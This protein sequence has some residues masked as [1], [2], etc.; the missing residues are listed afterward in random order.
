MIVKSA[1]R[2]EIARW[3]QAIKLNIEFFE[4][5]GGMSPIKPRRS[6][7]RQ[8]TK[9][10]SGSSG[11]DLSP[12]KSK[13]LAAV[14]GLPP[15]D[16]FL[17][18]ELNRTAT[19]LSGL[20]APSA[21]NESGSSRA[22]SAAHM[23]INI[24]PM[25]DDEA[26]ESLSVLEAAEQDS[27]VDIGGEHSVSPNH[28]IPHEGVFDLGVL[29]LK[30]QIESL[31]QLLDAIDVNPA[32]RRSHSPE[33]DPVPMH[34]ADS[35]QQAVKDALKSSLMT[36]STL[37]SS[38]TVMSQDRERYL[39][40]RI[41]REI[42]AR[43]VW[44][45]NMMTVAEQQ[46]ETDRQL[47]EAAKDNEK[48][49]KALRKARGVLAGLSQD[50]QIPGSPSFE[51][52]L[53]SPPPPENFT[54]PGG[55]SMVAPIPTTLGSTSSQPLHPQDRASISN[56]SEVQE[57]VMAAGAESDEEDEDDE[58]F[59]AIETNQIPNLQLHD[60]IAFPDKDRVTT[61]QV[62]GKSISL[63]K[64]ETAKKGSIKELL[65][66]QSLDPYVH[67]RAKLPID[68]DKRPSVSCEFERSLGE[69]QI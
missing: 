52:A 61:P 20:S 19:S 65:A 12:E 6:L 63:V 43:K 25:T 42:Q 38:Q 18:S 59:D 31:Q 26:Q 39:V 64:P 21:A 46:A 24:N 54:I 51:Q 32:L 40:D 49:R 29:N 67:I 45:E 17:S 53:A 62:D 48:K 69:L 56:I 15:T 13:S 27:L 23:N 50:G 9:Q 57:A 66:R 16:Q 68:D 10:F 1:H 7:E 58:F 44:E 37:I 3:V 22:V 8:P 55:P 2:A 4:N 60:S 47:T 36:L 5:N 35:R 30:A 33:K 11:P 14:S 34:R 28:G 41:R